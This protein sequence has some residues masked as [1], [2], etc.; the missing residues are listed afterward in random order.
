M[1]LPGFFSPNISCW[2]FIFLYLDEFLSHPQHSQILFYA[3][4]ARCWH[5]FFQPHSDAGILSDVVFS[6][7][8]CVPTPVAKKQ[9]TFWCTKPWLQHFPALNY[10]L[11]FL[12]RS[13]ETLQV[14][15]FSTLLFSFGFTAVHPFRTRTQSRAYVVLREKQHCSR[16]WLQIKSDGSTKGDPVDEIV[17]CL[18]GTHYLD[19]F[20]SNCVF[21]GWAGRIGKV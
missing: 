14:A 9:P 7:S 8:V 3:F 10:F 20:N 5:H 2:Y 1:C 4:C 19:G 16:I 11:T 6:F 17:R 18:E 13:I 21:R 15:Y 12:S